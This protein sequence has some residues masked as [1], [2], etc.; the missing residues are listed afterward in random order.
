[1]D[2]S[3]A[4]FIVAQV[5][6][7]LSGYLL[8]RARHA[9]LVEERLRADPTAATRTRTPEPRLTGATTCESALEAATRRGRAEIL[10]LLADAM[11]QSK[12]PSHRDR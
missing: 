12:T 7:V 1:M 11:A 8:P 2:G 9:L 6:R 5:R 10:N 4:G 3:F